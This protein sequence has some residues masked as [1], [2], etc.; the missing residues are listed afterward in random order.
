MEAMSMRGQPCVQLTAVILSIHIR[1]RVAKHTQGY[2][3]LGSSVEPCIYCSSVTFYIDDGTE[4]M[5]SHAG[6]WVAY[7]EEISLSVMI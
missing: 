3:K 4:P 2:N 5:T 6:A 1:P 7:D